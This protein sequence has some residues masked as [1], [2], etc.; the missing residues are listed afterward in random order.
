MFNEVE[1][2]GSVNVLPLP[3]LVSLGSSMDEM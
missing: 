1:L 3:S 2:A